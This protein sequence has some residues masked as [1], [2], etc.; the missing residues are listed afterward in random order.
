[1][2]QKPRKKKCKKNK[3]IPQSLFTTIP[4]NNKAVTYHNSTPGHRYGAVSNEVK[5]EELQE[6]GKDEH[7][8][9]RHGKA[10]KNTEL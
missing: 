2:T 8:Y 9:K 10:S 7:L 3:K 1:M 4:V 6:S 5:L